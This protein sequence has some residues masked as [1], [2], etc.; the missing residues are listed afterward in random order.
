MSVTI[1][2]PRMRDMC[3]GVVWVGVVWVGVGSDVFGDVFGDAFGDIC[4]AGRGVRR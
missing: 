3:S 1:L 2:P 4:S